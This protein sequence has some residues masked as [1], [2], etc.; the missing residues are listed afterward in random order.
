[1]FN[2]TGCSLVTLLGAATISCAASAADFFV[3]AVAGSDSN[4]GLSE[5]SPWKT[6]GR[7][8]GA[9][10][11]PGSTVFLKR[12]VRWNEAL[13]IRS[14]G[15]TIDAYGDGSPPTLDSSVSVTGWTRPFLAGEGIYG[16]PALSLA[17][18]GVGG[19]GNLSENGVMMPFLEWAGSAGGTL[20]R[21]ADGSYTYDYNAR[22]LYIKVAVDPNTSGKTYLASTLLFG[23]SAARLSDVTVQN[24]ALTRFS[25]HG[26]DYSDCTRCNARNLSITK[27]GGAVV[28]APNIYAGNGVQWSGNSS[29]GVADSIT[30]RDVFD[31]GI[32][33]QT[34]AAQSHLHDIEIRNSTIDRVGFAGVEISLLGFGSG[35]SISNISISDLHITN[36]GRGWSGNRYGETAIG[37]RVGDD[38]TGGVISGVSVQRT[39]V[40]NSVG[41]G[42]DIFGEVGTVTLN[43]LRVTG[44]QIG[45]YAR[46]SV[47]QGTTL[48]VLMSASII[49][50]NRS[51]GF[52]YLTPNGAGFN[53]FHNSFY[54]N[55]TVNVHVSGQNG[56]ALI[57]N[58]VFAGD[59]DMAQ[60]SVDNLVNN[61]SR[62]L[63]GATV[64]NNCYSQSNGMVFYANASHS[65]LAT[66]RTTTGFET[67]GVE[68]SRTTPADATGLRLI[69][70]VSGNFALGAGSPCIG[71]GSTG[72]GIAVDYSGRA[73]RSTPSMGAMEQASGSSGDGGNDGGNP[74]APDP[75]PGPTP[76]PTP[77][78]DPPTDPGTGGGG[79]ET[80]EPDDG[81]GGGSMGWPLLL[82]LG[83]AAL[84]RR[85]RSIRRDSPG[86]PAEL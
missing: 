58:N 74:G 32:S 36:A 59:A 54:K 39:M 52:Q 35:S 51:D 41:N 9:S 42:I 81:S 71:R 34:F 65:A 82:G 50:A 16:S 4:S 44:N 69:D 18:A 57:E 29:Y 38:P 20:G 46:A 47:G 30:V 77:D 84:L 37:V 25:L 1:M 68:G 17:P 63:Y 66:L 33:P 21:A 86:R 85:R 14:S 67:N 53:L 43:R 64:D 75:D 80:T 15:L 3:D 70:P 27:G 45:M 60:I 49:D 55:G 19:L 48:K 72:T 26:I 40:S 6:L 7:V 10:F 56:Q 22:K 8:S 31:S 2:C 76:D 12:G 28:V 11:P 24:L 78:P 13:I 23:V 62:V 83:G 61:N 79:G 5:S 73:Y